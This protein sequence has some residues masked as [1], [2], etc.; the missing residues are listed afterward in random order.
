VHPTTVRDGPSA[1]TGRTRFV[2]AAIAAAI[3]L[4][5]LLQGVGALPGSFMSGDTSWAWAGLAL[6]A[7][8]AAYG[9]WPRLRRR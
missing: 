7:A 6:I 4:I 3:G 1:R 8:A 2:V 9:A 5:W